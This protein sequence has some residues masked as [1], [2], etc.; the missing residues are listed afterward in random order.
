MIFVLVD[1]FI[2]S[3]GHHTDLLRHWCDVID[4]LFLFLAYVSLFRYF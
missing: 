4:P 2:F 1:I 3:H